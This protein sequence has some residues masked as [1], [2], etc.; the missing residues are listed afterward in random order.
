MGSAQNGSR[1]PLNSRIEQHPG[2][3]F[4]ASSGSHD[5][6]FLKLMVYRSIYGTKYGRFSSL[7]NVPRDLFP[8]YVRPH[9]PHL[10]FKKNPKSIALHLPIDQIAIIAVRDAQNG[11]SNSYKH[12]AEHRE[13]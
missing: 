7:Y 8:I 13:F 4:S 12:L 1:N 3:I 10:S 5:E 2:R 9:T 6:D 11:A